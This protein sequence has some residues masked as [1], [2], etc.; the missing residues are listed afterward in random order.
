MQKQIKKAKELIEARNSAEAQSHSVK[1]EFDKYKDQL[2]EEE[3]TKVEDAVKAVETASAG[4]DVEAI[5]KSINDMFEAASPV[6]AKKQAAES[7]AQAQP[8]QGEQ[9]VDAEFKEV[10]K[11]D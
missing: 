6:Y 5:T 3:R 10:D 1:K 4:E 8:A 2:T 7:A 11:K 9:T